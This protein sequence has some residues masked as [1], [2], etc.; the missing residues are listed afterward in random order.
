MNEL[1]K[2]LYIHFYEKRPVPQLKDEIEQ[3][4]QELIEK[5][6]KP[7]RKLVL[8]I[9]D[10]KDQIAEELSI[11][12]FSAGFH[13]AW[14]LGLELHLYEKEHPTSTSDFVE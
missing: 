6:D 10:C 1:L 8:Q 5:L 2:E 9:I 7:E 13:L 3:C 11:D 4:H 14:K 12:S